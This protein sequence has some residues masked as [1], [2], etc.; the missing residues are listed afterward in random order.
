LFDSTL[1]ALSSIVSHPDTHSY[2][3]LSKDLLKR[4]LTLQPILVQLMNEGSFDMTTPLA[5]LFVTFGE[6]TYFFLSNFKIKMFNI[7]EYRKKYLF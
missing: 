7:N 5:S 6:V 3:N 2:P 1:D 4:I